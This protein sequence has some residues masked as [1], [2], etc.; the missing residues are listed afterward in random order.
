[1]GTD[2]TDEYND[3]YWVG[4]VDQLCTVVIDN[5]SFEFVTFE[6]WEK[7]QGAF[8]VEIVRGLETFI[9]RDEIVGLDS[10]PKVRHLPP[11]E[12]KQMKVITSETI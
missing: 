8:L 3:H 5:G 11:P 4:R 7:L 10:N 1:M 6:H 12:I 9:P 2:D